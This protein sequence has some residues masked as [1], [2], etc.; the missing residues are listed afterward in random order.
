M[1]D[2]EVL[3]FMLDQCRRGCVVVGVGVSV[4]SA[5]LGIEET[6]LCGREGQREGDVRRA[7]WEVI[8]GRGWW[9]REGS[10]NIGGRMR[11][12]WMVGVGG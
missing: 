10:R 8:G 3:A 1:H 7:L 5:A 6:G 4:Y 9:E 11:L 2:L 12:L